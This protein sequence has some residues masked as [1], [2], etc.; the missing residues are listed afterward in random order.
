MGPKIPNPTPV[1]ALRP[2]YTDT[3]TEQRVWYPGKELEMGS[4]EKTGQAALM[5]NG[6]TRQVY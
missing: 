1:A 2:P 6:V 4:N 5:R 3:H